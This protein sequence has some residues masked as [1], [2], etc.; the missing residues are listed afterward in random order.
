MNYLNGVFHFFIYTTF[1]FLISLSLR[2][3]FIYRDRYNFTIGVIIIL[4]TFGGEVL[5][6]KHPEI[7]NFD[8]W[9]ILFD[10]AGAAF[11]Y[12]VGDFW[13]EYHKDQIKESKIKNIIWQRYKKTYTIKDC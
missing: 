12:L 8:I 5:I 10:I 7:F 4:S 9:M 3:L 11:G 2:G 13:S 1:I 6:L